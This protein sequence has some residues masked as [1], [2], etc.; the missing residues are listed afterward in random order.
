MPPREKYGEISKT[1]FTFHFLLGFVHPLQDVALHQCLP[2]S[3]V[4]CFPVSSGP[5]CFEN[6]LIQKHLEFDSVTQFT[7]GLHCH[8]VSVRFCFLL[9]CLVCSILPDVALN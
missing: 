2:L 9:S 8:V 3:S 6:I 7:R 1:F 4:C 5:L